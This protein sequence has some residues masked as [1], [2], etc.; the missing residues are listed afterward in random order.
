MTEIVVVDGKEIELSA[1]EV[2]EFRAHQNTIAGPVNKLLFKA[3]IW[4]RCTDEE[5]DAIQAV[6][7]AAPRRLQ[8]IFKDADHINVDDDLYPLLMDG[9]TQAVGAERA[10]ELL[11][12][13][14]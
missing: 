3:T 12:P 1:G 4:R 13:E 7:S 14:A 6:L 5:Y 11:E 2:A 9:A 10:A 8:A